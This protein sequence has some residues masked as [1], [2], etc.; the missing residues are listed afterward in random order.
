VSD[1][2]NPTP[3]TTSEPKAAPETAAVPT[4]A[5]AP[6]ADADTGSASS[7][8]EPATAIE[9]TSTSYDAGRRQ[10]FRRFAGEL[11]TGAG[12]VVGAVTELRDRSA[13]E[14]SVLLSQRGSNGSTPVVSPPASTAT[15]A[16]A[17]TK[18]AAPTAEPAPPPVIDAPTGFRTPFRFESEDVLL[19]IDQ[20]R[21]PDQ[22]V[23]VRVENANDAAR[24]IHDM[25]VRGAPAIGQVAAIGLALSAKKGR[26]AQPHARR[27]IIVGGS[28]VLRNA[29]P[30]AVNLGWAVDRLMA[31][32]DEIGRLSKE[33]ALIAEAMWDEAMAIV[34]EATDDHGRL[35]EAG[36]SIL[37]ATEGRPLRVL[38][39]CNTGPLACGQFG[40]A[41]GIVQAA[42]AQERP[43]HV[44]VDETRPYLQGARL[45][46]WELK[47]A[48]VD[49]TLIPDMAAGPLMAQGQVDV[50]IVGADRIAA[51]GDTANKV[52]TYTLAVLAARHGIPFV[53]AAPLS[54]VD[55][56]TETGEGIPIEDRPAAE[57]TEVRGVRIAPEG[58]AVRNPAFDVT[59]AELITAIVTE[60]GALRA[61][62]STSLREAMD[63]RNARRAAS[64]PY[65]LEPAKPVG[66]AF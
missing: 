16:P 44:W 31:R 11:I 18:R 40:T 2:P 26:K 43:L 1:S 6:G 15:A 3:T 33:G 66:A 48:G 39:H 8:A 49:H 35:A 37:P 52:G 62:Y 22:L 19:V 5:D 29:R 20:R 30:T 55:L 14:A 46:A 4:A 65:A 42:H 47:Q 45:T 59:P 50:I 24:A 58:T 41:L 54:S 34:A 61:P 60:E 7:G 23:E 36:Q 56:A 25:V 17:A 10:F 51:N 53:I 13:A 21:L 27:S 9:A 38:T 64:K 32:Y 28:N 57:V 63:H 12:Q